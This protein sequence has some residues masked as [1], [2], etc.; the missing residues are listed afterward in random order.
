M[1]YKKTTYYFTA[2]ACRKTQFS[3]TGRL[4]FFRFTKFFSSVANHM[5]RHLLYVLRGVRQEHSFR[6]IRQPA[7][8][9][10]TKTIQFIGF[11]ETLL[12]GFFSFPIR[13]VQ[14]HLQEYLVEDVLEDRRVLEMNSSIPARACLTFKLTK[15]RSQA[16]IKKKS[17]TY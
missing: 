1:R 12:N 6:Y 17:P 10:I 3:R 8:F 9:R 7:Q 15:K 16:A 5:V 14:D 4:G 2:S 13:L 11:G